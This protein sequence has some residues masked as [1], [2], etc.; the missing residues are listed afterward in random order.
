[1]IFHLGPWQ[2]P[3]D[4]ALVR[5]VATLDE[6]SLTGESLPV[7]KTVPEADKSKRYKV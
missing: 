7:V 4:M 3:C 5:G 1:M 6:A 2:L